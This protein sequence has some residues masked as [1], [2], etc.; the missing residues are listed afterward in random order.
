LS[1]DSSKARERL[2]WKPAWDLEAALEKI[3]QWHGA[4][5]QGADMREVS[6]EQIQEF[7]QHRLPYRSG[8]ISTDPAA[9]VAHHD[10]P[11]EDRLA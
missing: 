6:L 5:D 3:A 4:H 1:L 10:S 8:E 11:P 2:G 7:M 9:W